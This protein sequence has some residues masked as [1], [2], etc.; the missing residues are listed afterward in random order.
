MNL[1]E[2]CNQCLFK[3]TIRCG[4]HYND[5]WSELRCIITNKQVNIDSEIRS[6]DCPLIIIN[7]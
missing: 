4:N 5:K 1:P 6:S 2:S 3:T 7:E